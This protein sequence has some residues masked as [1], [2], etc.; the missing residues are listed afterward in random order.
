MNT[1]EQ[2]LDV[3]EKQAAY[4]DAIYAAQGKDYE[5]EAGEIRRVIEQY[6]TSEGNELLDVGCGTGGHFSFLAEWYSVEGLDLDGHMLAVA[7]K[8][9]P[10]VSFYQAD[11]V[12]FDLDKQ[13]DAVTCLFSS[14]EY[15]VICS[16]RR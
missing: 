16:L 7:K 15:V 6:K 2:K 14:M 11:M 12:E 10:E 1:S 9:F 5:K 4:Y 8:R 13:F 3:Y